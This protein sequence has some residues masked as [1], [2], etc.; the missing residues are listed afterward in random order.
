M[1]DAIDWDPIRALAQ[2]V[3]ERGEVL[4]LSDETR[5][6]LRRSAR[7]VA[8]SPEDTEEALRSVSSATSLLHEIRGRIRDGSHRLMRAINEAYRLRDVGEL[9]RA[10]KLME[11]VLA[12]EVVPFYREQAEL[13][14]EDIDSGTF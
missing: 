10:R 3:L 6:L 1:A 11:D 9:K 2:R 5:A 7:E 8:L 12:V 13:A 14:L 4:D